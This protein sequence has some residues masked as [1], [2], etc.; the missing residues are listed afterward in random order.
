MAEIKVKGVG[1]IEVDNDKAKELEKLKRQQG[2]GT[3]SPST[4]IKAGKWSGIIGDIIG[5]VVTPETDYNDDKFTKDGKEFIMSR[6]AILGMP[7]TERAKR[8]GMFKVIYSCAT[9]N[10]GPVPKEILD[11]AY[12]IQKMF[13]EDNPNRCACE[14]FL[15]KDIIPNQQ[16][17][18]PKVLMGGFRVAERYVNEDK[19]CSRL[20]Y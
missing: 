11:Q 19:R 4:W 15:F 17:S 2:E 13:F 7:P 8:L 10:F 20:G 9:E 12:E 5:V 3:L 18:I 16:S 14:P 1:L 6:Q